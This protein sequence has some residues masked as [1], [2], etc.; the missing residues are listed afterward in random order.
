MLINKLHI[1][2]SRLITAYLPSK[3]AS[4]KSFSRRQRRFQRMFHRLSMLLF[5]IFTLYE[6]PSKINATRFRNE[7][8]VRTSQFSLCGQQRALGYSL[9]WRMSVQALAHSSET[10]CALDFSITYFSMRWQ[11]YFAIKTVKTG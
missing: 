7:T 10:Y 1:I 11:L 4:S 2:M 5:H 6:S 8:R 9:I 3:S